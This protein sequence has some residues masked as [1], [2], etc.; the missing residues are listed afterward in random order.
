MQDRKVRVIF[1]P[2]KKEIITSIKTSLKELIKKAGIKVNFPCGGK[3]ICGKCKIRVRGKLSPFTSVEKKHLRS[4][5]KDVR[6]AC[7][8]AIEG[9]V[10][11]EVYPLSLIS[12]PK[13]LT[14]RINRKIKIRPLI[15]KIYLSLTPPNLKDQIA[16]LSRLERHLKNRGVTHPL[17]DLDLVKRLPGVIREGGFKLTAVLEKERLLVVEKGDTRG[18]KF[19]VAFDVGTTTV[20]GILIDLDTGEELATHALLNPQASFGED[21]VSR[22]DFLQSHPEGLK[23]L[24]KRIIGAINQI[25]QRLKKVGEVKKENIYLATFVGNTVMQHLLLGINP[26]NLA[27]YPYVP[28]VKRSMQL[29]ATDLGIRINPQGSLYF[30]PNIAAFVGGDTVAVILAT[31]L[32][33]ENSQKVRLAIDIGTNGEIVLAKGKKLVCAST[34]AGPAFE[35]ARISQG[36]RAERGAIEKVRL[37]EG[38]IIIKVIGEGRARGIC[39]S[40]LIDASSQFLKEKVIDGSGRLKPSSKAQEEW[41]GRIIRENNQNGF[42]LVEKEKAEDGIPIVLTQKDIRELQLAKGAICSGIKILLTCLEVERD[43]VDEVLLAGAFGSYINPESAHLIG[44]IPTF[45]KAKVRSVGNAASLGAIM[46]LVSEKDRQ[47]AERISE[48][49]DYVELASFPDFPDILSQA[50]RFGKQK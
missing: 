32:F 23:V 14:D 48:G 37:E 28:V 21:V 22:I 38:K 50:M 3:G 45:P 24:Q 2:E 8:V 11:V 6:L 40:G 39:G 33:D 20:V 46:A 47:Q 27:L 31:S 9:D 49:I 4:V 25:I 7:Q 30:F 19:G 13:I 12:F 29:K 42:L 43:E 26:T 5:E 36:M 18:E 34:A 17:A 41:S 10:E 15:K 35:G 16:D 1:R 44:L